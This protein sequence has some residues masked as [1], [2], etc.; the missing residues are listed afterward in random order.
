MNLKTALKRTASIIREEWKDAPDVEGAVDLGDVIKM[1]RENYASLL[2]SC[3]EEDHEVQAKE[4]G[5][6]EGISPK[7]SDKVRSLKADCIALDATVRCLQVR[8][9]KEQRAEGMLQNRDGDLA[10]HGAELIKQLGVLSTN[11]R[12]R[13]M[14]EQINS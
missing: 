5:D 6:T 14:R 8:W 13:W 12:V 10:V 11:R 9:E 2:E 4:L 3:A 1:L 7:D